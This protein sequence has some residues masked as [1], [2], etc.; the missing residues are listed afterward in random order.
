MHLK[1]KLIEFLSKGL[2]LLQL[3]VKFFRFNKLSKRQVTYLDIT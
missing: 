2:D 3:Y 1:V